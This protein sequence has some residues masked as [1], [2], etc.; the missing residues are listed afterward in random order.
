M[1][2]I[3]SEGS[4]MSG[5]GLSSVVSTAFLQKWW[6]LSLF[7]GTLLLVIGGHLGFFHP[8]AKAQLTQDIVVLNAFVPNSADPGFPSTYRLILRNGTG[9]V[10]TNASLSHTLPGAPDAPGSLVFD[11]TAPTLNDCGGTFTIND[12]GSNPGS[13]GSFTLSGAEIPAGDPGQ[14]TIE[15]PVKGF[16]SGNHNDTIAAGA[17]STS[18]GQN[19]DPTSAT[20]EVEAADNARITKRF[21][22]NTIPG[23]GRAIVTIQI[24]NSNDFAL[25]GTTTPPTLVDELPIEDGNQM[26]VD[27]RLGADSPTTTCPGGTVNIRPGDTGI[28]LVGATIPAGNCT[29]TFPVTQANGGTYTNN[30]PPNSLSTENQV[31]NNNNVNANLNIQTEVSIDKDMDDDEI[32]EGE[33]TQLTIAITNGSAA[34]ENANLTDNLPAPLV[35]ADTPNATTNC[36]TS[37]NFE[38]GVIS[39]T[40]G[41]DN[42]SLVDGEIPSSDPNTNGLGECEIR[43]DV[44]AD[45]DIQT[46]IPNAPNQDF[47]RATNEILAGAL[48]NDQNQTNANST[49]DSIRI[50]PAIRVRKDYSNSNQVSPGASTRMRIR[51]QNR[52]NASDATNVSFEDV[53]PSPLR[54]ATPL[55]VSLNGCGGGTIE[56]PNPGTPVESGDTE[57]NLV[58]ATINSE[59]T[60]RIFIDVSVPET[61]STGNLNNTIDDDTVNNDQGFDSD[62]VI[63][64]EGRLRVVTRVN[65]TKAFDENEIR[66]GER[67]QFILRIENNRRSDTSGTALPLTGVGI[68]DNLPSNLHVANPANFSNVRCNYNTSTGNFDGTD[69]TF[70]GTIPGSTTFTME[71]ATLSP[72]DDGNAEADTCEIRFDVEEIDRDFNSPNNQTPRTYINTTSNFE[73]DQNEGT[74]ANEIPATA[75]LTVISPLDGNKS[76]QSER[77]VAGGRSTAVIQL[78]NSLPDPLTVVAFIDDWTQANTVVADPPNTSTTCGG[79]TVSTTPGSQAVT[80]SGGV[81]PAQIGGVFGLCEVR[82][83]VQM[84]GNGSNTFTNTIEQGDI[85]TNEGFV[86]P[87]DISGD[88][89]RTTSNMNINKA[90]APNEL[91]VGDPSTLTVTVTNPSNGIPVTELGFTD[92]MPENMVVFSLPDPTTTCGGTISANPGED[93][94]SFSG[95]TLGSDQTCEITIQATL[96]ETGNKINQL[97]PGTVES[98]ENV[99]NSQLAQATLNALTALRP[100]KSFDPTSVEGGEPSRLT[101]TIENL[102]QDN[103]SGEPLG[104]VSITD[105]L[106]TDLVVASVPNE[107]TDCTDGTI[108]VTPGGTVVEMTGATLAPQSTCEVQVDVSSRK[109]G[110]YEN[111]I[112]RGNLTGEMQ[113]SLQ[114]ASGDPVTISNSSRPRATLEVTSD[115][116]PPEIV[117]IK[118]ITAING[119]PLTGFVDGDGLEDNDPNWPSPTSDSLRGEIN[120]T[121]PVA[122]GDEVEYT[123]YY[124]NT[125]ESDATDVRICDR[126]PGFT[127]FVPTGYDSGPPPDPNGFAGSAR[128]IVLAEA[129]NELSQTNAEDGDSGIYFAPGVDPQTTFPGLICDG[130]SSNGTV[131]VS[132]PN[133]VPFAT[134]SGTPAETYGYVRFKVVVD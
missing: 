2:R 60:C 15:I 39:A 47:I 121:A 40:P 107:T 112:E 50:R 87:E 20:L 11:A 59:S 108:N 8:P 96:I 52:S 89:E 29:I 91:I 63:G 116:L 67:S 125:G 19:Q 5:P 31:S 14:C 37:G 109:Q 127:T 49:S 73:N 115:V 6:R 114:P 34:L 33:V 54:V 76:F 81:V 24:N 10:A 72:V 105:T 111:R 110:D 131:V 65:V 25:T 3:Q 130:D 35:V 75:N 7:I 103:S 41:E 61:A 74:G 17:L 78:D 80:L 42:F 27:T 97:P 12:P 123:V 120:P 106:P 36:T 30:I 71:N 1:N 126:T 85:T 134:G 77:I 94:Y 102:Q 16:E 122:P 46:N 101:L 57:I 53:F 45:P 43:I 124:L 23:N 129:G 32:D 86:N 48:T 119:T 98:K 22:P 104:N 92:A 113:P 58:G 133:A 69:P 70:T 51:V 83:D 82:F 132:I 55:V 128:G 64:G 90:F 84:D 44:K 100:R 26:V 38:S 66:R 13:P 93:F 95:G 21:Q 28:E 68:T 117:L 88:L 99:T 18:A 4:D 79:G 9:G 62:G 118:R 56:G